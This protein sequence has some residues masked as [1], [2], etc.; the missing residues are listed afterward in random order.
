[1]FTWNIQFV[2]RKRL[3]DTLNQLMISE[4]GNR[5]ILIRIHTAVH[6]GEE[7]ADLAAFI[8]GILPEAQILGTSTSAIISEGKLIHDQCLISVTQMD[9]GNVE[10][11]RIPLQDGEGMI[12][13]EKRE[14]AEC[15]SAPRPRIRI[16]HMLIFQ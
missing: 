2:S 9:G 1:M 8:K 3:A 15:P 4:E 12:P 6:T 13:A 16:N 14:N 11:C 7:A 5:N 10:T